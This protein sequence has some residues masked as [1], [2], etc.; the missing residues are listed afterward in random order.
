MAS[1]LKG[2]AVSTDPGLCR[3][4]PTEPP[5]DQHWNNKVAGGGFSLARTHSTY[6]CVHPDN[7]HWDS[8]DLYVPGCLPQQLTGLDSQ[9]WY[10]LLKKSPEQ[11]ISATETRVF[12]ITRCAP[13]D[14]LLYDS[15]VASAIS[16]AIVHHWPVTHTHNNVM[17][18]ASNAC[19]QTKT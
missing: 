10:Y 14:F 12:W 11:A 5:S 17:Y 3:L 2:T 18:P 6:T 4:V 15:V 13:E 1:L 9:Y 16:F 7:G 8:G 19:S